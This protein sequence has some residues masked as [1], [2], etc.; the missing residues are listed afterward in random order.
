MKKCEG[1]LRGT[2]AGMCYR[3]G[4][5]LVE[6]DGKWYC[7][8]H[9][10]ERLAQLAKEKQEEREKRY[11]KMERKNDER[12]ER[13][14]LLVAAGLEE[15]SNDLLRDIIHLGGIDAMIQ[16]LSEVPK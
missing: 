6:R 7:W 8:Q 11:A 2:F 4:K 3:K 13:H 10:P 1:H 14:R 12:I 16:A 5:S 9:D 15:V